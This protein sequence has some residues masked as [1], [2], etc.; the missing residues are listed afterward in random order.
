MGTEE[1]R[2]PAG[3]SE[4][5]DRTRDTE[6][7]LADFDADP[8]GADAEV[9]RM[10]RLGL[11]APS[12]MIGPLRERLQ[13][14]GGERWFRESLGDTLGMSWDDP[15]APSKF[16]EAA[17]I[18]LK[19]SCKTLVEEQADAETHL[20]AFVVYFAVLALGIRLHGRLLTRRPPDDVEA[21]LLDL[22]QLAP[23]PWAGLFS[24]TALLLPTL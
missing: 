23:P 10:F 6:F 18:E 12:P 22:A 20:Q 15:A 9:D 4:H 16:T 14:T 7:P 13:A 24:R 11:H 8:Q 19:E 1:P 2:T 5:E 17:L 3:R 21:V